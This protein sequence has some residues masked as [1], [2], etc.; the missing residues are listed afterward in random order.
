[1]MGRDQLKRLMADVLEGVAGA[2]DE[3]RLAAQLA[4]DPAARD[5]YEEALAGRRAMRGLEREPVPEGLR[6]EIRRSVAGTR[7]AAPG[8]GWLVAWRAVFQRRP[9]LGLVPAFAA[10]AVIGI[11]I[12]VSITGRG[13][14]GGGGSL[15]IHGTMQVPGRS[16]DAKLIDRADLGATEVAIWR[17][18][19]HV[20][21]MVTVTRVTTPR[22]DLSF[23]AAALQAVSVRWTGGEGSTEIRPG[24]VRLTPAG[25]GD[26][27]VGLRARTGS[28]DSIRVAVLDGEGTRQAILHVGS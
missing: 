11:V 25:I 24:F 15:P 8:R 5:I 22:I 17:S 10:G 18:G 20:N 13:L 28:R 12:F 19:E 27:E 3:A 6:E 7:A 21:V 14:P 2:E 16:D 9:A 1:M 23:D 4:A 26:C